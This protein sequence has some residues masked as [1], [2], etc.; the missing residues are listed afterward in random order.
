MPK[1]PLTTTR[2]APGGWPAAYRIAVLGI[3]LATL[4]AVAG[5]VAWTSGVTEPG[6]RP[7]AGAAG[8][9]PSEDAAK[10]PAAPGTLPGPVSVSDPLAYAEAAAE[11]LWTYDTRTTTRDQHLAA[12]H[13]WMTSESEYS[14]WPAVTAQ[15]PDPVLWSRMRDNGQH[16]GAEISE[17]HYPSAFKRALAEDPAALTEAYIYAVTVTGR[18]SIAWQ[19]GGAGAETRAVTLAVQCRPGTDCAL[20]SIAPVLAP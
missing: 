4:L 9:S 15:V 10:P 1:P 11:M 17:A 18:Q 8:P 13:A 6:A 7:P 14:D 2:F 5:F 12:M 19:D 16:A 3:V 20:V